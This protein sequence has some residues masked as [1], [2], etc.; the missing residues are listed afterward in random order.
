[1]LDDGIRKGT[2]FTSNGQTI[3]R[4]VCDGRAAPFFECLEGGIDSLV[5]RHFAR[6]LTIT[7]VFS[8]GV[9]NI[10]ERGTGHP[11]F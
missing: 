11:L 1:M 9:K 10:T 4:P 2:T 5:Q 3:F 6:S 7:D 8:D